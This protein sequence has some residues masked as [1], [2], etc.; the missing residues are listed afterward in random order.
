MLKQQR[1]IRQQRQHHPTSSPPLAMPT[2]PTQL[3][4]E[5]DVGQLIQRLEA[6]DP[7]F[8]AYNDMFFDCS[9]NVIY[10]NGTMSHVECL[11]ALE[12]GV[13]KWCGGGPEQF[14]IT[15]C[16]SATTVS[17]IYIDGYNKFTSSDN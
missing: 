16:I 3:E 4:P 7:S 5:I 12:Q 10:G 6:E 14:H 2:P 13:E 9:N 17:K 11:Q 8:A 1:R 15:K